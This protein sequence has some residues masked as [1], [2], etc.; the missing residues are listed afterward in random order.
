MTHAD[1][2]R[3]CCKVPDHFDET[4][5][6]PALF[7]SGNPLENT[8]VS[9]NQH[10]RVLVWVVSSA[11]LMKPF[12]YR[13]IIKHGTAC[14]RLQMMPPNLVAIMKRGGRQLLDR[15]CRG[16]HID[17][18]VACN[19]LTFTIKSKVISTVLCWVRFV[20]G[21]NT[22]LSTRKLKFKISATG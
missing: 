15:C 20:S 3:R 5:I 16:K 9:V 22:F 7:W 13:R 4:L 14:L 18:T 11:F 10:Y 12:H 1:V 17:S 2:V 6:L 21:F 19:S 8:W